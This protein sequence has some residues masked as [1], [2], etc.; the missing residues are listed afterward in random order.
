MQRWGLWS[1]GG[2]MRPPSRRWGCHHPRHRYARPGPRSQVQRAPLPPPPPPSPGGGMPGC[3]KMP[4]IL[5]GF[6]QHKNDGK[7][8]GIHLGS[9]PARSSCLPIGLP[10]SPLLSGVLKEGSRTH[11]PASP[12]QQTLPGAQMGDISG[13]LPSSQGKNHLPSFPNYPTSPSSATTCGPLLV[14][15]PVQRKKHSWC[16]HSPPHSRVSDLKWAP[17]RLTPHLVPGTPHLDTS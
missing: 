7:E 12:A 6:Q 8:H 4:L 11:S 14:G 17:P 5:T 9:T 13:S 3:L 2:G 15:C 16:P 1:P 10:C